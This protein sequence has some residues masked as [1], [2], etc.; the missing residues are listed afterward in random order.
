MWNQPMA[1]LPSALKTLH[2]SEKNAELFDLDSLP[3]LDSIPVSIP[4]DSRYLTKDDIAILDLIA[5][6]IDDRPIYFSVT[7]KMTSCRA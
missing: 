7:C 5:S 3:V 1:I 2:S 4:A 6:N